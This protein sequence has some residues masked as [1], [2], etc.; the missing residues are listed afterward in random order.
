MSG[1]APPPLPA[2][3]SSPARPSFVGRWAELATFEEVWSAVLAG[4]RQVVFV[5]GE[6]GAGKSRL[7]AE[8][9]TAVHRHGAAVLVGTCAAEFGP[10]YQ[11]FGQPLEALIG[12]RGDTAQ[13]ERLSTLAGR[14]SPEDADGPSHEHR[15]ALYDAAVD[16]LCAIAARQPLVLALED[17]HW[18][19]PSSLQLLAHLVERT[20]DCP[21]LLL[22][23]HRTTAPDRSPELVR[24]V[25]QLYRLD[26]VRRLDLAGLAAE[27]IAEYLVQEG[28]LSPRAARSAATVLR[29]QTGGNPFF[30]RE[31]WRDH[32]ARGGADLIGRQAPASVR[33]T[34]LARLER[35]TLPGRQTAELA[36]VVGE[37]VDVA[38][39]LA[40]A[41]W[42]R[43]TTLA[44]LDE[45]VAF[46][47][48]EPVPPSDDVLRFPH[49]LSRQA[50]LDLMPASRR[51]QLHAE[52]AQ[53]VESTV[54]ASE[55]RTQQLAFHYAQAQALGHAGRAV[56]YL[57]DA[58]RSAAR[59]LA[60][61]D[62]T[63]W[64][65][66]AAALS[67]DDAERSRLVLSAAGSHLLA[68]DFARARALAEQ[69][70]IGAGGSAERLA[71]AIA[72]EDASWRPGLPGHRAVQLLTD[73][74]AGTHPD[75]ADPRYVRG[76]ASLGRAMAFTGA[77]EEA[78]ALGRRAV[79]LAREHGDD[80]LLAHALQA[81][82]WNGLRPKDAPDKLAR[83]GELSRLADRTGA[84]G[85]LGPAAYYR[86][87]IAYLQGE[88]VALAQAH[89]DLV[90]M[91]R[92]TGQAF[93]DYMAGCVSYARQ[94]TAGDFATAHR[95][96]G[97]LLDLGTS[98]GSD[99]TEGPCA[100]QSYMIRRE[101]GVVG[102]VRGLVTGDERPEE[103]W[104]PGLLALYT[105]LELAG[106]AARLLAWLLDGRLAG[107]EDS[108]QWPC[109]LAYAVEAALFLE[110]EAAARALRPMMAEYAG[111]NLVAGQFVAVFGSADR[112]LG[113]LD[114]L[115]G[116]PAEEELAA[117]LEMDARMGSP[118]HQAHT[119]VAQV[120]HG[121]RAG[122]DAQVLDDLAGQAR[123][124]A[125]LLDLRRVL[126][127][128]EGPVLRL[129]SPRGPAGLTARE[130]EV[131]QLLGEGLLNREIA[132]RL[133]ISENTAANH[134]RSILAKTGSGNRTQAAMFAAA[135]G[136]L[137]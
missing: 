38:T 112:Y 72:Y 132:G 99:D 45:A 16:A 37:D 76:L 24:A 84:L 31:L 46:G 135:H 118:L 120:V 69:V 123:R 110:D 98:F 83:A 105:E 90:R 134:V 62:A 73:A 33:D 133:V 88:P 13:D 54:P 124:L 100:V 93:F 119:L 35:L 79:D 50:V 55:R 2:R 107:F 20:A 64:F 86:G 126:R 103:H 128:L 71:G 91:A 115:L 96:C 53:A 21:M 5:G 41:Q 137:E 77:T 127:L 117:A 75:P 52:V 87:V 25:A 17:L 48:L 9:A 106:P 130:T 66:Q 15:R 32:S 29:D 89:D 92:G 95:T 113:A 104:A 57:T 56:R 49:A 44:G 65:E 43:E 18:A 10:P 102:H 1:W 109:V 97:A 4:S 30:L 36:A 82:L 94:F 14:G 63:R 47:L 3:W 129:P 131:L 108:A 68:G 59:S 51:L 39:V 67:E 74:L 28:H 70:A 60:H 122:A 7:L 19:G 111:T 26:G 23:T 114:S 136:L 22:G 78:G 6:P 85:H 34:I 40:A 12:A 42:G 101:R 8:V 27:D 125:E 58:A 121:R 11:P 81:S 80:E 116:D 61:E